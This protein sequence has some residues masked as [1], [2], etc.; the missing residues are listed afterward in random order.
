MITLEDLIET[1][2][3]SIQDEFDPP[4]DRK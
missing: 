1:V 2:V 4:T 3:G